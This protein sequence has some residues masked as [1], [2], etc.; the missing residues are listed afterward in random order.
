[1]PQEVRCIDFQEGH[2]D[3]AQE[4]VGSEESSEEIPLDKKSF[5]QQRCLLA[6]EIARAS[7]LQPF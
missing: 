1:V 2:Q 7:Q 3:N 4:E 5:R 6:L